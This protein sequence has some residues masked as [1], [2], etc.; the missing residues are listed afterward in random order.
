ME[1]DLAD[2]L[3]AKAVTMWEDFEV[4]DVPR[5]PVELIDAVVRYTPSTGGGPTGLHLHLGD[6]G[7]YAWAAP[8]GD[9]SD[10]VSMDPAFERRWERLP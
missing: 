2:K 10:R 4:S 9:W 1:G 5:H 7:S 6:E 8:V 3:G